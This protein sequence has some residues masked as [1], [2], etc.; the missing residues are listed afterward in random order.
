V[1][2]LEILNL[3]KDK[4]PGVDINALAGDIER[5][6]NG[7]SVLAIEV[8]SGGRTSDITDFLLQYKDNDDFIIDMGENV[9]AY[10]L[11]NKSRDEYR[12]A[13]DFAA[14]LRENIY[15]ETGRTV[16][17]GIGEFDKK[18]NLSAFNQSLSALR[19]GKTIDNKQG[20]FSYKEYMMLSLLRELPE[21][22]VKK[23]AGIILDKS[24][25]SLFADT[26]MM[27]TAEE[28][29]RNSLNISETSR[30]LFLHRNTLLY[31]LDKIEEMT[32]LNIRNF[33]DAM[34]LKLMII[35]FKETKSG[36]E[37]R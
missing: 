27:G 28:F 13:G 35:L 30:T 22:A 3:I 14:A 10:L 12:S 8:Q 16:T 23:Y 19:T 2:I 32:G 26:E 29:L 15:N 21:A 9:A 7:Y 33:N 20:V 18:H 4:L 37:R 6:Q 17:I 11:K 34:I 25:S 31:R 5:R 24:S 1:E 36:A